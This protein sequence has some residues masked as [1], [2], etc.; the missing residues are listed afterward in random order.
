MSTPKISSYMNCSNLPLS[1]HVKTTF[2]IM[3]QLF[4]LYFNV[5]LV[6]DF[7]IVIPANNPILELKRCT[8]GRC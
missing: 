2:L 1:S 5:K 3:F 8:I 6:N 4:F 7:K